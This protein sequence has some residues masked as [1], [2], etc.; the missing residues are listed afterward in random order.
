V[1]DLANLIEVLGLAPIAANSFGGCIVLRLAAER[2]DL[3]RSLVVHEPPF[4]DLLVDQSEAQ[5][6]LA[7]VIRGIEVS[8]DRLEAGEIEAGVRAFIDTVGG[9]SGVWELFPPKMKQRYLYNGPTFL[10]LLRNPVAMT[11]DLPSLSRFSHPALITDGE[12]S[13]SF[14]KLVVTRIANVLPHVEHRTFL[15]TGH[16]PTYSHPHE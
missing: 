9:A 13:P 10:F 1:A 11:L 2:P 4:F 7:E 15:G 12:I 5:V 16:A 6:A 3:F 8:L 14:F